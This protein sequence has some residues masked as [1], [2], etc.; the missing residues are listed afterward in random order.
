MEAG[1]EERSPR[2]PLSGGVVGG[3]KEDGFH[4]AVSGL[5]EP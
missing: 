2:R 3:A 5:W 1:P 4:W